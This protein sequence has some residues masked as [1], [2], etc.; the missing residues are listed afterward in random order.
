[1]NLFERVER[2]SRIHKLIQQEATG[3]PKEFA[4][5]LHLK[6]R[7]LYYILE[8]LKSCGAD[9]RF[10]GTKCSYYYANDFEIRIEISTKSFP[11][12]KNKKR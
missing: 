12:E 6:E 4:E 8:E 3:L 1:M 9:I 11:I 5:M 2:V 7:Q 10:S